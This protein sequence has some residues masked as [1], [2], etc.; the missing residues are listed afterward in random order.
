MREKKKVYLETYGCQM[1]FADSEI[2]NSILSDDGYSHTK[3]IAEADIIFMNT[4]A[5]RDHAEKRVKKRLF[6]FNKLKKK[7]KNI[8]IGV[9]GCMAERLK[10]QLLIDFKFVDIIAGPDAYRKLPELINTS[11]LGQ[12]TIN[13]ILSEEETY[14]DIN[15]VKVADNGVSAFISIMRGCQ[16]F[17][18]YCVVPYTRGKER[19]R[20]P[21]T[22]IAE[23]KDLIS[24]G[25]KEVTLL[26]QNVNSYDWNGEEK[27]N[28]PQLIKKVAE[29]DTNLR[30][31]FATSHPKD[32]SDELVEAIASHE[33]ICNYVH[34]PI[35]SGSD[36][37][38]KKMNRKYT[39]EWYLGRMEKIKSLIPDCAIST[40]IITG[41]CSETIED[42]N[43]TLSIMKK[44]GY[45]YAYMFKYSERPGTVAAKRFD[46]D[47]P[48]K[49]KGRR[50]SEIIELQHKLSHESNKADIGKTFTVLIESVSKKSDK[51]L[52]GRSPQNKMV[53]F[54]R[55]NYKIGDYVSVHI[56]DCTSATLI[57]KSV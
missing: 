27:T 40:D 4:C 7:N 30:V 28:F 2:V 54:P 38:L 15:P 50:L 35:Q 8:K 55:K 57:G 23:A 10:E 20:D 36:R 33:N 5:I 1:N 31:R 37:I 49:E 26:G 45:D 29:L 19:S 18:T 48:E 32:L 41:F 51:E 9:L 47:I 46:D 39:T 56:T 43:D 17:C 22:I 34:L 53:V 42:H 21:K 3:E 44:V 6:E 12:Q 25:Y 52:S 11:N 24:K 14:G 13:V 16:N